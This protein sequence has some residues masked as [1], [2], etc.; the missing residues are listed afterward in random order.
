MESTFNRYR[1]PILA[2]VILFFIWGIFGAMDFG[3]RVQLG[4]STD[5]NFNIIE[6]ESGSPAE[7]AGLLVGDQIK[8]IDGIDMDDSKSWN[9]KARP[10]IG[11]TRTFLVDRQGEEVEIQATF[12][13]LSGSDMMLNYAGFVLG[14]IFF[15]TGL[16]IFRT[17]NTKAGLLFAL[18]AVLFG[19]NFFAGPYIEA[20]FL[21]NLTNSISLW[22][23]L[24]GFAYL[25]NF[26]LHYPAQRDLLNKSS[27][28]WLI[29]APAILL[30][31]LI[32]ILNLFQP[33]SS[34]TLRTL[35]NLLVGIVVLFYFVWAI[36][37]MAQSYNR[38]S[39]EERNTKG[40]NLMLV[41][42]ILGLLPIIIVVLVQ[43]L[44]PQ[45]IVP[46]GN[47]AFLFLALIPILF[48]LALRKGEAVIATS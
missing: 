27:T 5:N 46:G 29:F 43:T 2:I 16:W 42:V 25:V 36:I 4:Y 21:R 40:L 34:S 37:L 41:G 38:A 23:L 19:S 44:A 6:V 32:T 1:L 45:I 15:L 12:A 18:F 35:V 22:L 28:R 7:T 10:A 24:L 20:P 3:N 8:R 13:R 9:E 26:L 48:A 11:E 33:E 17:N 14:I 47:Y 39:T 30:A 31:V